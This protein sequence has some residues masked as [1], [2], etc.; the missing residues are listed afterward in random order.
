MTRDDPN[1]ANRNDVDTDGAGTTP[2]GWSTEPI[3]AYVLGALDPAEA[4][5]V[6][7]HLA[8]CPACRQE[9][10]ELRELE[11]ALGEVPPELLLDGPPEGGDLLLQRTLRRARTERGSAL[12]RRRA[13]I[14]AVAAVAAAAALVLGVVLGRATGAEPP[15]A[16]GPAPTTAPATPPPAGTRTGSATDPATGARMTLTVTPAMGWVRVNAAVTGVPAGQRCHLVVKGRSG[17]TADAGSWLVSATGAKSGTALDGSAI[18][19]PDDVASVSVVNESGQT[20][21]TVPV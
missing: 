6:E 12:R 17:A 10:T 8:D 14:G 18:V 11:T 9:V 1:D 7:R 2:H 4:A 5:S 16:A 13:R 21:V 15:V 19:A 20:F 3:G